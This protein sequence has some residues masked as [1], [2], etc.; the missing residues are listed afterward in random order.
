MIPPTVLRE[1]RDKAE[2]TMNDPKPTSWVAA[3]VIVVIWLLLG[4]S[5]RCLGRTQLA[6]IELP[7]EMNFLCLQMALMPKLAFNAFSY[8]EIHF[9]M[10]RQ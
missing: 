8:S 2:A 1:C 4:V 10:Y 9:C 3:L 6:K 7:I 5:C